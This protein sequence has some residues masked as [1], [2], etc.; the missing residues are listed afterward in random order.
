MTD[1]NT[2]SDRDSDTPL[3]R[4]ER[5]FVRISI[6][7]TVLALIGIVTGTVAL[8][9]ALNEADAVRKQ[10]MASVYPGLVFAQSFNNTPN[11]TRFSF[12]VA[13]NGIGPGRI[14]SMKVTVDD[15]AVRSWYELTE[16]IGAEPDDADQF[17]QS[18]IAG[19]L[20]KS[21]ETIEA[22]QTR[23]VQLVTLIAS[24]RSRIDVE[25]CYCSV[26]EACWTP[27]EA[28]TEPPRPVETCP[29]HGEDQFLQ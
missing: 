5:V 12:L 18:Q 17:G 3:S 10:Q 29:D 28:V 24:E 26:F 8:Y 16:A 2:T 23:N 1:N 6:L 14:A 20:V 22:F 4:S 19:R 11:D 27:A 25:M 21:G 7:Q 13:N 9:A 15:Q